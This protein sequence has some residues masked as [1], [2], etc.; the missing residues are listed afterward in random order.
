MWWCSI[1]WSGVCGSKDVLR[2]T[3]SDH[4]AYAVAGQPRL[5]DASQ[6]RECWCQ[7]MQ[8][9]LAQAQ[10]STSSSTCIC[11]PSKLQFVTRRLSDSC[12]NART[13]QHFKFLLISAVVIPGIYWRLFCTL[14]IIRPFVKMIGLWMPQH[15]L[16]AIILSSSAN[17]AVTLLAQA[18]TTCSS[19]LVLNKVTSIITA[20]CRN[21][22]SASNLQWP[23]VLKTPNV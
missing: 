19:I 1:V 4:H 20:R 13:R 6:G 10:R 5:T 17:R 2:W 11:R 7:I 12:I 3:S 22:W 18:W 23:L 14:R 8:H 21:A 15:K 16:F 9:W